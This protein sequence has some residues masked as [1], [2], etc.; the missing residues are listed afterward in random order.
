M[1]K[2]T[3]IANGKNSNNNFLDKHH[4]F[5]SQTTYDKETIQECIY[6]MSALIPN[7]KIKT[8]PE[9]LSK[10]YPALGQQFKKLKE[11]DSILDSTED[12]LLKVSHLDKEYKTL[13]NSEKNLIP[14]THLDKNINIYEM[15]LFVK[16]TIIVLLKIL[17]QLTGLSTYFGISLQE[18]DHFEISLQEYELIKEICK[19]LWTPSVPKTS[20]P[21][22]SV[23]VQDSNQSVMYEVELTSLDIE[24]LQTALVNRIKVAPDQILPKRGRGSLS[25]FPAPPESQKSKMEAQ[26]KR[27][28]YHDNLLGL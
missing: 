2:K 5:F 8:L 7:L 22:I 18:H 24:N 10:L 19:Y 20:V 23:K 28:E 3:K 4:A 21:K 13:F 27:E 26:K 9:I 25:L 15:K 14:S 6:K 1:A 11:L 12:K 17:L 16:S